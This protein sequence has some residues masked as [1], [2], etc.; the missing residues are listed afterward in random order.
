MHNTFQEQNY[1]QREVHLEVFIELELVRKQTLLYSD[2]E[3][4]RIIGVKRGINF[5][6]DRQS[7][8]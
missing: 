5:H 2:E 7:M 3:S 4:G 8:V 6:C 1:I